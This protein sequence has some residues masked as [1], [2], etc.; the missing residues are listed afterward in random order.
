MNISS[1]KPK[2]RQE[3][4]TKPKM[5]YDSKE[6][7]VFLESIKECGIFEE[8]LIENAK[9]SSETD[10]VKNVLK[11]FIQLEITRI[12]IIFP[13]FVYF[14]VDDYKQSIP[15]VAEET[16]YLILADR[17]MKFFLA[18]GFTSYYNI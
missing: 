8:S 18:L 11:M 15:E 5:L 14:S 16:F 6:F 4:K 3:N 13:I 2:L 17:V 12:A 1:D 9:V 10:E 7:L